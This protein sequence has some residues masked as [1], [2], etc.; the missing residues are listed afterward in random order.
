MPLTQLAEEII[1]VSQWDHST[2]VLVT[3]SYLSLRRQFFVEL[4]K[5]ISAKTNRRIRID[6]QR[7]L[8]GYFTLIGDAWA[9][10]EVRWHNRALAALSRGSAT[11]ASIQIT[12]SIARPKRVEQDVD[13]GRDTDQD[14]V[15]G[16]SAPHLELPPWATPIRLGG[17]PRPAATL[18]SLPTK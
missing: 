13:Q 16:L 8:P 15:V 2:P 3:P 5:S 9:S 4:V 10:W 14:L 7:R 12:A 6:W 18:Q 11:T 17:S 1:R